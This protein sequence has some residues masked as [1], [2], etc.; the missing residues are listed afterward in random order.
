MKL[1]KVYLIVFLIVVAFVGISRFFSPKYFIK[2][3]ITI[4]QPV[5]QTFA[6][7]SNLKNW[8]QWS[9]W[10]KQTDST[11]YWFY[12]RNFDTLGGRQYLAGELIGHGFIEVV[13]YKQNQYLGYRMVLREGDMTANGV[14]EFKPV[15]ANQT[16]LS[17]IDSGNVGNN[18]I[19]RYMI[20]IVT[21]NTSQVFKTGLE[22]IRKALESAH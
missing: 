16:E 17:W 13:S 5:A 11:M 4:N 22:N 14:F 10:N 21:A 3:S 20:P 6:Y 2:E 8:E 7:L 18:P 12:N 19:K 15:G 9:A 1:F